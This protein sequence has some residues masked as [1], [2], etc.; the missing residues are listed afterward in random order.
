LVLVALAALWLMGSIRDARAQS[1]GAL[2]G[3]SGADGVNPQTAVIQASDGNFY[4]TT[5]Y[6]GANGYGTVFKLDASGNVTILHSFGA[7]PGDGQYPEAA[8]IQASDGNFYGTTAGGGAYGNG[9][10]FKMDI[11]GHLIVQHSFGAPGSNDGQS[12]SV[13]LVQASDG[14]FYGTT[15]W[16]GSTH[17]GGESSAGTAFKM[18][19]LGNVTVLHSFG[20]SGTLN[21]GRNPQA[22]LIQ[23]KDGNFYGTTYSSGANGYG[24]VFKMDAKGAVTV[25]YSFGASS[26]DGRNPQAALIQAKDG[27][28][29]GTTS[30][31]GV[32]GNGTIFNMD[33]SDKVKVLYSF[34]AN[35][36]HDGAN[37]QSSLLQG[38]DG[39]FYGTT[40]EGGA[41]GY[42]TVY[43]MAVSSGTVQFSIIHPFGDPGTTNDG[44]HPQAA[45]IQ[46]SNGNFYGTTYSGGA[47]YYGTIFKMDSSDAVT[48]IHSFRSSDASDGRTPQATLIQG[49][50]GNFYGTTYSGGA[51][52][53]GTVFKMDAFG[54]VTILHSFGATP[55]DGQNPVAG[56]IQAKN[57]IF[58]GTTSA[59][60]SNSSGTAFK[61]S[62]SSSTVK[63]SILH[64]FADNSTPN[65]GRYPQA[66]LIQAKDGNFYGTTYY[67]GGYGNG[68]VF[69]MDAKGVVTVL[70]SFGATSNDGHNPLS[71][72]IQAKDGSF[73]GTTYSGGVNG[74]G[75]V[76]KLAVSSGGVKYSILHNCADGTTTNDG[77]NPQAALVQGADGN[78]Y[79]TTSKGG[80]NG[81]GSI[82]KMDH[83]GNVTILHAFGASGSYDGET[84]VAPLIQAAD[85]SFYGTTAAGGANVTSSGSG[86]GT[87]FR[88]DSSGNVTV[89][90]SFG[91]TVNDGQVPLAGLV[92][93]ANHSLYGVCSQGGQGGGG[94]V[95]RI[96]RGMGFDAN[97]D[98]YSDIL[99]QNTGSGGLVLWEMNGFTTTQQGSIGQPLPPQWQLAGTGD[100]NG[101]GFADPLWRHSVTGDV[102]LWELNGFNIANQ[103][104]VQKAWPL[105]WQ[106]AG[107]GDF[108]GDCRS[109][110]LWRNAKTGDV[111]LWEMNGLTINQNALVFAALPLQWQT[112]GIGD[113]NGDGQADILWRNT[114]TGDVVEWEMD[115]PTIVSQSVL[116][117]GLPLVWQVVGIGDFNGD[118]MDDILWRNTKTGDVVMW[119]MD[120]EA[121]L[122]QALVYS[123]YPLT[124]QVAGIGDFNGDGL[125][126]ILWR[127]TGTST[128][129]GT[130]DV[131]LWE[132][133]GA[134][135]ANQGTIY[136][137]LPLVWQII[138]P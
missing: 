49:S 136:S 22:A 21:D 103:G 45:L 76:F 75:T 64:N 17:G 102:V 115:G 46:G 19:S 124:W 37:P 111:V 85:G 122:N 31:G 44:W 130:G 56:L 112:A 138:A 72:L 120:G 95:F 54:N 38:S 90:H 53:Y 4:G 36:S 15:F 66:A 99:F 55:N 81:F 74:Y 132:M 58:Y 59:G 106:T 48:V 57:G 77:Q 65:D 96:K 98:G 1:F 133:N 110:I 123:A 131:S 6:G 135:I 28:F 100:F 127:N 73:Y 121:I 83:S 9:T 62:V 88:M 42:G 113:F 104:F 89:I 13:S 67:G 119:E 101:D 50:D 25:L 32:N 8:L 11:S 78:L 27:S 114:K 51:N 5:C 12:P 97:N 68:T 60:G 125:A 33:S 79:G 41:N 94:Q 14:N 40:D 7:T 134:T 86:Y 87:A 129:S 69:K 3:F 10:A 116:T 117:T 52:G 43:K 61:M 18:D 2:H 84:P 34:G 107:I 80:V 47:K 118:G 39:N 93:A 29:Y 109:D 63:F 92:Q 35:G 108:N 105:Q 16:G 30:S 23:A 71:A 26:N 128:V 126:D 24:T 137:A 20:D 91:A 70:Y 82:F